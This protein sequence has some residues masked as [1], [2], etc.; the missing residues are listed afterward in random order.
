MITE[1]YVSFEIA[2]LLKEK[3]FDEKCEMFYTKPLEGY[4]RNIKFTE[5][6]NSCLRSDMTCTC[7][8][9]NVA[10]KWLRDVYKIHIDCR[11]FLSGSGSYYY[12]LGYFDL[13]ELKHNYCIFN[14]DNSNHPTIVFVCE[15]EKAL[16][17]SLKYVLENIIK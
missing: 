9:L 3:G 8:T 7:P 12:T 11:I 10:M 6:K 2:K 1:D 16:S 17:K 15:Y 13:K 14:D 4:K 5:W